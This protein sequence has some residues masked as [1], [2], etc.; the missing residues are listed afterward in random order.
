MATAEH[1]QSLCESIKEAYSAEQ[2]LLIQGGNSKAFYGNKIS[3][4][5]LDVTA[6]KGII[7]YEPSEL[8]ITALGG[9]LLSDI[10]STLDAHDQMLAFEPAHFSTSATIAGTVACGLSGPR[11]PYAG[12]IRDCVL[13]THII[14]GKGEYLEFGGKVMK[15]VAGYD[16][17][18]LM[19]G[20]FGTLGVITQVS[21]KVIP[22]PQSEITLA[23]ECSETEALTNMNNWAQTQI[24][25]TATFFIDG[26]LYVR[27]S[28]L[29]KVTKKIHNEFGGERIES[30]QSFW[31][32][33][34][35]HHSEFFQT[36][37]PLWRCIVPNN[38][39]PLSISGDS[40]MEWNGG[41]RWIKT[42]EDSEQIKNSCQLARGYASLFR[43]ESK[44]TDCL[45]P[46]NPNLQKL[47]LNLK[48]AFD[49]KRILN[50]GRMYSWY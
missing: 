41:L 25:I 4:K 43:S 23:I 40:C 49:P 20:A 6:N 27:M 22:T 13:G 35:N 16:V 30:S 18:R 7:E 2:A 50:P 36:S 47:H 15:N 14:N 46:V 38:T 45:A 21:L 3:T 37:D 34:K 48:N 19:C 1:I 17:S 44:P 32:S 28:G 29:D 26:T 5:P 39:P 24:P 11:R 10:E 12:S 42:T 31:N 9:T 8:F 33:I